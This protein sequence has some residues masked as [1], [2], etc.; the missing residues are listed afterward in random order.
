MMPLH[1]HLLVYISDGFCKHIIEK[2]TC[3]IHGTEVA[4]SEEGGRIGGERSANERG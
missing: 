2:E 4:E 1:K 3:F